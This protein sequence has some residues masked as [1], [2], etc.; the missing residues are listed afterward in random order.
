M[1]L[2]TYAWRTSVLR[3]WLT[4]AALPI[5]L[6]CSLGVLGGCEGGNA[7]DS[8]AA[9]ASG[10]GAAGDGGGG[11]EQSGTV[12][13]F[14]SNAPVEC[15]GMPLAYGISVCRSGKISG[16]ASVGTS[17]GEL[18][19]L[20]QGTYSI[21]GASAN[22]SFTATVVEPAV[23]RGDTT[24]ATMRLEYDAMQD[25]LTFADGEG[26]FLCRGLELTRRD[27][28]VDSDCEPSSNSGGGECTANVDCADDERCE[29][30]TG[31]CVAR[32]DR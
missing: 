3:A 14:W 25:S 8:G 10:S 19:Q 26:Q 6:A 23:I 7:D 27:Q 11:A 9:G 32:L 21:Q 12:V 30:S 24:S 29:L 1:H 2:S 16:L 4:C 20:W 15:G 22:L 13:G 5:A 17:M 18:R 28:V 31:R